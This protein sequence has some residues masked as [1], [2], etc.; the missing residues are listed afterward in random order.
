LIAI[1]PDAKEEIGLVHTALVRIGLLVK[2]SPHVNSNGALWKQLTDT[3]E[4]ERGILCKHVDGTA[5]VRLYA[6]T[7]TELK[8]SLLYI[9]E[10]DPTE[11]N[12]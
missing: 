9:M 7:R 8:D 2:T 4:A 1:H 10:G 5:L 6:S 12:E 11:G 3:A